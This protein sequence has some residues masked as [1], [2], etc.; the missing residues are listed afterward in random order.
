M[1]FSQADSLKKANNVLQKELEELIKNEKGWKE[2]NEKLWR[3]KAKLQRV[4]LYL[5]N[6]LD[7]KFF[8]V[9]PWWA[10]CGELGN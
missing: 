8:V 4:R 3:E 6:S 7:S 5:L 9:T 2:A 1:F 10:S